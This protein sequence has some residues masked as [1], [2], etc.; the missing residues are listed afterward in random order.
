VGAQVAVTGAD[1]ERVETSAAFVKMVQDKGRG[2]LGKIITMDKSAVSM[3]TP[4]TKLQSRQ[5]LKKGTPGPIK[6]KVVVSHTKQMLLAFFDDKGMVYTNHVPRGATMNADYIISALKKFLKALRQKRPDL[7][8]GDWMFHWDN[9]P[10]HTAQKVQQFLA[11]KK[12]QVIHHHHPPYSPDLAP[13]DYFLFPR[14]K[15]ELVGQM[16]SLDEF[17]TKWEGV[18]RTLSKDDFARA[19]ERWLKRCKKCI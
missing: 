18:I 13:A 16:L 14:L 12:I 5:W 6:A 17:K 11:K 7:R 9:A 15:R 4:E 2:I 3:H 8:P 1:G 19:F 10:V